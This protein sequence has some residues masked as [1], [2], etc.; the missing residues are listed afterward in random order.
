ME[1]TVADDEADSYKDSDEEEKVS[2]STT[3]FQGVTQAEDEAFENAFL[4]AAAWTPL[5]EDD[6][7]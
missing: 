5:P 3:S 4:D 6:P 2:E 7:V 1:Q